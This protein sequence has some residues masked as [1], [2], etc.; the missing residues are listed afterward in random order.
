MNFFRFLF[1]KAFII[2]LFIAITLLIASGYFTL[3]WLGSYTHHGESKALRD[4]TGTATELLD[5]E[6]EKDQLRYEI[7]DTVNDESQSKGV[8]VDQDPKA[9]SLVKNNRTIYLTVNS[10]TTEKVIMPNLTSGSP[11]MAIKRLN[12]AGLILDSIMSIPGNYDNLVVGQLY[13]GNPIAAGNKLNKGSKIVLKVTK[14]NMDAEKI[15]LPNFIG[16]SLKSSE[17]KAKE[18]QVKIIPICEDCLDD[19]I[20]N[21]H[22]IRQNPSYQ[23][24]KKI[25]IGSEID[26]FFEPLKTTN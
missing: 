13:K 22:V 6:F 17:D 10:L 21:A 4:F 20:K 7:I 9:F 23:D 2:S 25:I 16:L 11:K 15:F 19:E 5:D 3:N 14:T 24:G 8:V 26:L 1:S 18:V 12:A